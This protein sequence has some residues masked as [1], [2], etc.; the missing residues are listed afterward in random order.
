[1]LK[2]KNSEVYVPFYNH[3]IAE[4]IRTAKDKLFLEI[5]LKGGRFSGKSYY[6]VQQIIELLYSDNAVSAIVIAMTLTDHQERG[7][8]LFDKILADFGLSG[9]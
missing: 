4:K 3:A 9:E 1:M 2:I 5:Y 6:I 8:I 7:V